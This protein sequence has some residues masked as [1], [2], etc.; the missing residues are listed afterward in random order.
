VLVLKALKT[1]DKAHEHTCNGFIELRMIGT[2]HWK[3][4]KK[5]I[6]YEMSQRHE[7]WGL[8][9][10]PNALWCLPAAL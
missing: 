8:V 9:W 10:F 3:T 7:N 4:I 1:E 5:N 2:I 6:R